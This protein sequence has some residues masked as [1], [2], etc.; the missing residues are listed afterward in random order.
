M[1]Q[2]VT[3]RTQVGIIGAGPA[4]LLL[5]QILHLHGIESVVIETR[6]REAIE[7]TIRAGV[8]EQ[9][10]GRPDGRDRRGR[11]DEA[12]GLPFIAASSFAF[13][14]A[15][16]SDRPRRTDR[17]A[18][19]SPSTPARGAQGPDRAAAGIRRGGSC[20][21]ARVEGLD[22]V[23]GSPMIGVHGRGRD[24]A[25]PALRLHRRLR[26]RP[27]RLPPGRDPGGRVRTDYFR[28]YPFGWFGILAGRSL[29]PMN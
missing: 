16:S 24:G 2:S 21:R 3:T 23:T 7:A 26:R 6:T 18:A 15:G 29:R 20:S 13:D 17:T 28:I 14:G 10:D 8:L 9:G 22:D 11:A 25:D 12:G 4:G 5:S 1:N 19:S 27:R